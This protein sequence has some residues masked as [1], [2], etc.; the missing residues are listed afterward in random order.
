MRSRALK[1]HFR[2]DR[3]RFRYWTRYETVFE[4]AGILLNL[5]YRVGLLFIE[6]SALDSTNVEQAFVDSLHKVYDIV[7]KVFCSNLQIVFIFT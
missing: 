7:S 1:D 3:E 5:C 4:D 6:T 2:E